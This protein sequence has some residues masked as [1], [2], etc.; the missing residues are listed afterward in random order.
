MKRAAALPAYAN[1]QE[2][3]VPE[4][5]TALEV[6]PDTLQLATPACPITRREVFIQGSEPTEFCELH[7]GIMLT[8]TP[9]VSW[10]SRLFGGGDDSKPEE[11][12]AAA[13]TPT[14]AA[15]E[16]QPAAAPASSAA[17]DAPRPRRAVQSRAA[18]APKP[19]E[20]E[21][22]P[23]EKKAGLL[24]RIFGIFGGSRTAQE[25]AK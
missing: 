14:T 5:L 20:P 21:P 17:A 19:P 10:L 8:Q 22:A 18:P 11:E 3:P 6:D 2:F 4:G 12:S 15:V 25:P 24:E 23:P 9:P 13:E 7:G 16:P 1:L